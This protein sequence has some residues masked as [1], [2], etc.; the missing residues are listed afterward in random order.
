MVRDMLRS[1]CSW[2]TR[3]PEVIPLVW[4]SVGVRWAS[5]KSTCTITPC[6]DRNAGYRLRQIE[7]VAIPG[8]S[9][10]ISGWFVAQVQLFG[11]LRRRDRKWLVLRLLLMVFVGASQPPS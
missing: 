8:G 11:A 7:I 10:A 5:E 1:D 2:N 9:D 6:I 4:L 3:H